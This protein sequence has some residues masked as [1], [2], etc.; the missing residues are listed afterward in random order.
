MKFSVFRTG[1]EV[2]GEILSEG[3][4]GKFEV[5]GFQF[6]GGMEIAARTSGPAF[7]QAED[8]TIAFASKGRPEN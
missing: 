6:E 1:G 2:L 7:H 5:F 4:V 3:G 8:Q